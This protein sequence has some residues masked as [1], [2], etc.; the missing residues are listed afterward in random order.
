MSQ[1]FLRLLDWDEFLG[2]FVWRQ[3]NRL[4][5]ITSFPGSFQGST[6]TDLAS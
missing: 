4:V 3:E 6:G 5:V 2:F 1:C